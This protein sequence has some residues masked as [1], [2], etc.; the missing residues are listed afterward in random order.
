M[1]HEFINIK[2]FEDAWQLPHSKALNSSD[3]NSGVAVKKLIILSQ[4]L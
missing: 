4:T 1:S 3:I 2:A